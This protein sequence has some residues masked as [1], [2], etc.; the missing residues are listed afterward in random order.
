MR[1]IRLG[2]VAGLQLSAAPSAVVASLV[3]W[4]VLASAGY[5]GLGLGLAGALAGAAVGVA[6]HWTLALVHHLGHARAARDAG[7]PMIGI[8]FWAVVGADL[9]PP[10]EPEL[11]AAVHIRRALGGPSV[12]FLVLI[13]LA[14]AVLLSSSLDGLPR[15]LIV[16]AWLDSLLLAVGAFIPMGF[17]DGDTLIYWWRRR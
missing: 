17:T 1:D 11:P 10:D 15:W 7:Y 13:A 14:V 4:A 6:I 2:K 8:R 12:S 16:W 5:W 9:Y 3:A